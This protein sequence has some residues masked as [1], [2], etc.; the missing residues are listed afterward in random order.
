MGL[1]MTANWLSWFIIY[2][3]TTLIDCIIITIIPSGEDHVTIKLC[4]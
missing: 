2:A 3:I 1:N 4:Y